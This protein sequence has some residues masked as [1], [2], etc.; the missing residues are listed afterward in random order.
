MRINFIGT[1]GAFDYELGNSAAL[2]TRSDVTLL[3][4]CGHTVYARL[5]ALNLVDRI[6]AVLITHLHDD[7]VGSLSTLLYHRHFFTPGRPLRVLSPTPEFEAEVLA[8]LAFAMQDARQYASFERLNTLPDIG[9]VD[10][11]GRHVPGMPTFA[12]LIAELGEPADSIAYSGDLGDAAFLFDQLRAR[13]L[14]PS[15]VYHDLCLYPNISA[16]A[17]YQALAAA[18]EGFSVVGYHH[19]HRMNP[20]E[21]GIPLA[22]NVPGLVL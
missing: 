17:H 16:H 9:Y 10:T 1:G 12:Y 5:R 7:H 19:D 13:G 11:T 22:A 2:V 6:D 4:D 20:P 14:H 3:I 8:F 18:N 21:N 15:T